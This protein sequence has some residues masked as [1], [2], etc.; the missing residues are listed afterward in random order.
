[1][2]SISGFERPVVQ[3]LF[4]GLSVLLIAVVGGAAW[5]ARRA[6]AEAA[7]ARS[8][9]EGG[10][11]ERQHLDAQ[12]ARE[13]SAREA[14]TLELSRA[15]EGIVEPARMMPTLT[16]E[17]LRMRGATPPEP[18]V[19]T[20]HATQV[21]ELR[22]RLPPMRA[23]IT[24]FDITLRNWSSGDLVWSRGGLTSST[25]DRRAMVAVFVTGDVFRP[26]AYELL[27]SGTTPEGQKADVA[28]YEVAFR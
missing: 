15:R 9:E 19:A 27:L 28:A 14:L 4:A 11:L 20:Q 12:L 26:G 6:N 18:T 8:M 5:V 23:P 2:R 10:R 17:P 24:R 3:W 1:M 7:A 13:R 22:L 25:L 21:I 16:L